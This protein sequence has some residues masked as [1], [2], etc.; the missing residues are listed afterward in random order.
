MFGNLFE[1]TS[2][3]LVERYNR[4]LEHLIGKRT[5]LTEFHLDI[6]G[7]S[8]EIGDELGDPLYLNPN[9]CNRQFILLST[10]QKTAPLLNSN[11]STSHSILHKFISANEN[12]LFA[13][14]ARDVVVGEMI[15]TVFA[16]DEPSDLLRMRTVEIEADTIDAHIAA[17]DTL[18]E[19]ITVF[20]DDK[21]SWWDDVLIA[22][23]IEL[24]KQTGDIT[25][26]PVK[27]SHKSFEQN[28]FYTS[29]FGGTYLFRDIKRSTCITF[30][31]AADLKGLAAKDI[32]TPHDRKKIA[33]FL[34]ESDLAE[35]IVTAEGMNA[36]AILKQ[37]MDFI[38]ISVAASAGEDLTNLSRSDIRRLSRKLLPGLPPE[39]KGLEAIWQ[40]SL[41]GGPYPKITS[42]HPA[43]FYTLRSTQHA[44]K[45]L[46]N[47]LLSQ[48]SPLDFRQLFICHKDAFYAAYRTWNEEKKEYVAKFLD[49]EYAVDKAG[50]RTQLFGEEPDMSDDAF[51]EAF[52]EDDELDDHDDNIEDYD[53][54]DDD[55]E[56]KH[57]RT[58]PWGRVRDD[59]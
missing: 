40:W 13:L 45:Q 29:H 36:S 16:I 34:E 51:H 11:F 12:Q 15:N 23:M 14:T 42:E 19:K 8:P 32:L 44:D 55:D 10:D 18:D 27:L 9:G 1:V 39:F 35:P 28:N 22:D 52:N 17:S 2:Q 50:A 59:D 56:R 46:V 48:L 21:D 5:A 41:N 47:M 33:R 31:P 38:V 26:Q 43:Y 6:S 37:K 3:A 20:M 24:A 7:Y 30:G 58:G 53:E 49:E 54:D 4:A 57:W 25:R